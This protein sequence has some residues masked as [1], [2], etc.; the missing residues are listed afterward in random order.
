M[1]VRLDAAGKPEFLAPFGLEPVFDMRIVPNTRTLNRDTHERKGA[2]CRE[3]WPQVTVDPWPDLTVIDTGL[4]CDWGA[5]LE[6]IQR[7][8]DGMDG[9]IDPPSSMHRL[10][11][12]KLALKAQQETCFLAHDGHRIT[13][14]VFCDARRD[15]L[16]VGKLAVDPAHQGKGIGR[17]LMARAEAKA[18]SLGLAALELQTR[19]ELAENYCVFMNLGFVKTGE[20]AHDGYERA[21]SITMRKAL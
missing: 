21:T 14:C 15:V 4:F 17:A 16:Y 13:G 11:P 20:T 19:I 12:E 6:L 9:R 8:F 10:T 7:A 1:A 3:L 2:R 18:R 5:L